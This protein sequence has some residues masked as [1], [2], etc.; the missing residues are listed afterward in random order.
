MLI[1]ISSKKYE[2]NNS[3]RPKVQDDRK[4]LVAARRPRNL[5]VEKMRI[6]DVTCP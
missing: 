6:Q 4:A 5:T 1:P 3:M 2:S